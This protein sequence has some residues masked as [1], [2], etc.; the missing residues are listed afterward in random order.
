MHSIALYTLWLSPTVI[1]IWIVAVMFYRRLWTD[2]PL[3]LSYLIFEILRTVLLFSLRHQ[4]TVYFYAYWGTETIGC[5]VALA[6]IRELFEN[7][8]RPYPGLKALGAFLFRWSFLLLLAIAVVI[9]LIAPGKDQYKILAGI[10]TLK[11]T[12]TIVQ[13]GLLGFLF[14]FASAFGLAWRHYVIGI[15]AGFG[16]YGAVELIAMVVRAKF[17][18]GADS[19]FSWILMGVNTCSVMIW[20]AYILIPVRHSQPATPL[21]DSARLEAWNRSLMDLLRK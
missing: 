3:F 21:P 11:R 20:A 9:A 6:V 16:I 15:A 19:Y 14:L 5:L 12:V 2:L 1:E 13:A 18:G 10:Y 8:F 7:V 4:L 17:G